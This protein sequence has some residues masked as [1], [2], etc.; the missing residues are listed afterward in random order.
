M[1]IVGFRAAECVAERGGQVAGSQT[2]AAP[3]YG[4][5]RILAQI[6]SKDVIHKRVAHT[7]EWPGPKKA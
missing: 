2:F 3:L 4:V 7:S 5:L 6:E 1:Y